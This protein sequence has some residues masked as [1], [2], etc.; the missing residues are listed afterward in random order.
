MQQHTSITAATAVGDV[1]A[2]SSARPALLPILAPFSIACFAGALATDLAY[3]GTP[4]VMWERFSVWLITA[5][6]I[7]AALAV[8]AGII[9]L[10]T[11]RAIRT[12]G[13]PHAVGYV[14][15]VALSLINVLV[16]SRDGYTAV[17]PTGLTLSALVVIVLLFTG[18][19]GSALVERNRVGVVR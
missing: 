2:G 6:L 18:W 4:E 15:A 3:W 10:L 7:V 14:L 5:G 8:I 11:G 17:V 1:R 12:L 19:L 13:W 9:D 16:H